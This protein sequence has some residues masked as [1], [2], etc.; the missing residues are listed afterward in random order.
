M[1]EIWW[2]LSCAD[3]QCHS[4]GDDHWVHWIQQKPSV[5]RPG[6]MISVTVSVDDDEVVLLEGNGLPSSAGITAGRWYEPR[7]CVRSERGG[8]KAFHE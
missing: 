8:E 2:N 7:C 3:N 6:P 4:Y 5:Q 1:S